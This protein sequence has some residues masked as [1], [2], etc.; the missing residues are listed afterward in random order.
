[1]NKVSDALPNTCFDPRKV[2]KHL[3]MMSLAETFSLKKSTHPKEI[4]EMNT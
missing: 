4:R 1:M 2:T 3:I